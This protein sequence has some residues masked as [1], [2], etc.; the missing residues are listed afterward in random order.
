[1]SDQRAERLRAVL[2]EAYEELFATYSFHT[3][4]VQ[5]LLKRIETALAAPAPEPPKHSD[6][7]AAL[8]SQWAQGHNIEQNEAPPACICGLDARRAAPAPEPSDDELAKRI[9]RA[10]NRASCWHHATDWDQEKAVAVILAELA[11][12]KP[13]PSVGHLD[14]LARALRTLRAEVA[15]LL[16]VWENDIRAA[17]GVTNVNVLKLRVS[18]ADE[19][20][21][22]LDAA[23]GTQG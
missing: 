10:L 2:A 8:W 18:E 22:A 23:R 6:A 21:R 12:A 19:V 9:A 11:R 13:E 15:G 17:V 7:C 14:A 3:P 16:G 4:R 5:P 20:L 1:M